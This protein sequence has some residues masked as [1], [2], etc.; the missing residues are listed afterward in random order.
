MSGVIF[1]KSY[2]LNRTLL[3]KNKNKKDFYKTNRLF[4]KYNFVLK[5]FYYQNFIYF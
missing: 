3:K 1:E 2:I 5:Q 4:L